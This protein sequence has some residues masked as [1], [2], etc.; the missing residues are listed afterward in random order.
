MRGFVTLSLCSG[1]AAQTPVTS[2]AQ[3][4]D[5]FGNYFGA[6]LWGSYKSPEQYFQQIHDDL[7]GTNRLFRAMGFRHQYWS[8]YSVRRYSSILTIGDASTTSTSM[9]ST[10]AANWKSGGKKTVV[11][12]STINLP[13]LMS[14][15]PQIRGYFD[16]PIFFQNPVWYLGKSP[17]LWEVKITSN[18][19]NSP[20]HLFEIGPSPKHHA[21]IV[22]KGCQAFGQTL[23]LTSRGWSTTTQIYEILTNAPASTAGAR[24]VAIGT[25]RVLHGGRRLPID[26]ATFGSPGCDLNIDLSAVVSPTTPT[27]LSYSYV[28]TPG[29]AGLRFRT[30]W[31]LD[32]N[33]WTRTSNGLNHALPFHTAWPTR[34]CEANSF[35]STFPTKG[36]LHH[37]GLVVQFR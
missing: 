8:V 9:S 20:Y 17:L 12:N 24:Y 36:T 15:H 19:S 3:L 34:T 2:P 22:G 27:T 30:Q 10:F 31:A 13:A 28:W 32:D 35:G 23:P 33:G 37:R 29:L 14:Y 21:G 16:T 26:L 1:L 7:L 5:T 18:S 11:I 25:T 6:T 4:V